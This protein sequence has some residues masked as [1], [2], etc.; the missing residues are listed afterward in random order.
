VQAILERRHATVQLQNFRLN[1]KFHAGP[2]KFVVV[3]RTQ[4]LAALEDEWLVW[5][6]WRDATRTVRDGLLAALTANA[7]FVIAQGGLPQVDDAT[8]QA[9]ADTVLSQQCAE[10]HAWLLLHVA[11][12]A[13]E[14]A[15]SGTLQ[16][17]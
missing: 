9:M 3:R 16:I 11:F 12:N 7:R 1:A 8:L 6:A 4:E 2:A 13:E 14:Q 10:V 15:Q 17:F 5:M